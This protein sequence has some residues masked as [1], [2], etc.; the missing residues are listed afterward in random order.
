MG[1]RNDGDGIEE[2]LGRSFQI[3]KIGMADAKIEK[4][5]GPRWRVLL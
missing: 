4:K 5:S 3:I 2:S 1:R